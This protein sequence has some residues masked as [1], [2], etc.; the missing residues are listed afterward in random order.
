[1]SI[2]ERFIILCPCLGE[3]AVDEQRARQ[4]YL[5]TEFRRS[6]YNVQFLHTSHI[7]TWITLRSL[8]SAK[9]HSVVIYRWLFLPA[10]SLHMDL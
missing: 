4:A 3:S 7:I 10:P 1:M 8:F 6:R 9:M 5:L 2:A